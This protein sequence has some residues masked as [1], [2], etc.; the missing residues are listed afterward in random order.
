VVRAR[1]SARTTGK[2]KR[3][4]SHPEGV[5]RISRT[6]SGVRILIPFCQGDAKNAYPWLSSLHR[7]AVRFI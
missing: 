4:T 5:S 2:S 6:P 1:F 3:L 7:S